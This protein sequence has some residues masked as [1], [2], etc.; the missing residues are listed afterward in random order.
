[1]APSPKTPELTA[2]A[3][4]L[5]GYFTTRL[6]RPGLAGKLSNNRGGDQS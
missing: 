6:K 4:F 3:A 5:A 2:I 1:M